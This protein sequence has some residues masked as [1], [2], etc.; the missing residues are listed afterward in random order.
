[1][2]PSIDSWMSILQQETAGAQAV[3][4]G[5]AQKLEMQACAQLAN[6]PDGGNKQ[7]PVEPKAVVDADKHVAQECHG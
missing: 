6:S 2:Y 4:S 5:S 7:L 1:M 3:A